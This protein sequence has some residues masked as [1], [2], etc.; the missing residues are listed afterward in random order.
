MLGRQS[1]N[2]SAGESH[3]AAIFRIFIIFFLVSVS[4]QAVFGHDTWPARINTAVKNLYGTSAGFGTGNPASCLNCHT[5]T[6]LQAGVY[7]PLNVQLAIDFDRV[8]RGMGI[9]PFSDITVTNMQ[10]VLAA[11]Q[12]LDSDSDGFSN[13]VEFMAQSQPGINSSRPSDVIAPSVPSQL[14]AQV[15]SA[16]QVR[17]S[18]NASSDNVGVAGYEVYRNNTFLGRVT[19]TNLSDINLTP[20]TQYTYKVLAYDSAGNKSSV[21]NSATVTTPQLVTTDQTKPTP[22]IG[23][24]TVGLTASQIQFDWVAATDNIGVVGYLIFRNGMQIGSS[25]GPNFVDYNLPTS[26]TVSYSVIALDAAGNRSNNSSALTVNLV[27]RVPVKP[28][29]VVVK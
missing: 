18:W 7:V 10:K 12:N 20:Q 14:I 21:S 6:S 25:S 2:D 5:P 26:G 29:N 9:K 1:P 27:G 3:L 16:T 23:L 24:R 17:V 13:Q 19:G 4:G 22:P 11:M 15:L 8:S 28:M